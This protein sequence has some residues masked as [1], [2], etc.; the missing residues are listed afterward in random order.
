MAER[1]KMSDS[2]PLH[3]LAIVVAFAA[4]IVAGLALL[5]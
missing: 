3:A 4:L 1:W 5:W 2:A